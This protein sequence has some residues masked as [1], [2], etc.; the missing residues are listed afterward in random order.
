MER[1]DTEEIFAVCSFDMPQS[2]GLWPS[3]TLAIDNIPMPLIDSLSVSRLGCRVR[4]CTPTTS[5]APTRNWPYGRAF[6]KFFVIG[7]QVNNH[8]SCLWCC[9]SD[10]AAGR[11][12]DIQISPKQKPIT[13]NRNLSNLPLLYL[14]P[15]RNQEILCR[16]Y[17]LPPQRT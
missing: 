4:R 1:V 9:N 8:G 12:T 13:T 15:H 5:P 16:F 17:G 11:P 2:F 3:V 7:I 14:L 6:V 10:G